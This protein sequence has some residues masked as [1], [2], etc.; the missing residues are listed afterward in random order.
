[1]TANKPLRP[2]ITPIEKLEYCNLIS[3]ISSEN[4]QTLAIMLANND[5]WLTLNV[6][7]KTLEN[8]FIRDDFGLYRY[9]VQVENEIAGIICIRYPWL[10]GP[11]IELLGL[12]PKYRGLGIGKQILEWVERQA[13]FESKNLWVVASSFNHKALQFYQRQGF[14]KIGSI[15]GLVCPKYDEILFRKCWD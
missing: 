9:L 1:M 13:R 7:A 5:P 8:Y 11:Y 6:S 4:I 15:N 12:E 2:F 10:R 3:L 14:Y